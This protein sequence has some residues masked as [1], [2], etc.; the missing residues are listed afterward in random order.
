ME[1]GLSMLMQQ[2]R[3]NALAIHQ[4]LADEQ[5]S[6]VNDHDHERLATVY[7]GPFDFARS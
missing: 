2:L 3:N 6:G 5:K 4:T 1:A 7:H